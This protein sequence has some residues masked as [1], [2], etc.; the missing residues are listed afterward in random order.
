MFRNSN[1]GLERG[2]SR[3]EYCL[4]FQRTKVWFPAP[5]WWLTA[6]CNS[7]SRGTYAHFWPLQIPGTDAAHR[8]MCRKNTIH[9]DKIQLKH[10]H[11]Y[12]DILSIMWH[13]QGLRMGLLN[14][15]NAL[16][17]LKE[18]LIYVGLHV[19][20]PDWKSLTPHQPHILVLVVPPFFFLGHSVSEHF[21]YPF[22]C[23]T[24]SIFFS[25]MGVVLCF[26]ICSGT[27]T[28]I[29]LQ[30]WMSHDNSMPAFPICHIW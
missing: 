10:G 9:K 29:L 22:L 6:V 8:H 23:E 3:K 21:F 17:L 15:R 13:M 12:L 25:D 11:F 19:R 7:S 28:I 5:R 30:A 27:F 14:P 1:I 16:S 24:I 18:R 26:L 4:L 20:Q 2:L